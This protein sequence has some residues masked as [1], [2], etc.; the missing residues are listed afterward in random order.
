MA[1]VIAITGA[2]SGLGKTN[3]RGWVDA[4]GDRR[5][6]TTEGC[7]GW[8]RAE[9]SADGRRVYLSSEAIC[10]EGV[11]RQ[12]SGLFAL[13]PRGDWLH[14]VSLTIG[15]RTALRVLVQRPNLVLEPLPA[16]VAS[17][18]QG[19]AAAVP[20]A[21]AA[22][23]RPSHSVPSGGSDSS[24]SAKGMMARPPNCINVPNQM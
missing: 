18:L 9:W 11:T 4:S 12:S 6:T 20:K 21:A 13:S 5:A 1:N 14:V 10:Q 17:A 7:A 2:A 23:K 15:A 8:E 16:D 24:S 22:P 3:S 19:R